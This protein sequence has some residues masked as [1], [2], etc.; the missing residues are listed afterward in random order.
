MKRLLE[1]GAWLFV[2][3]SHMSH[4]DLC[5]RCWRKTTKIVSGW[6]RSSG[7][8]PEVDIIGNSK[9]LCLACGMGYRWS[10]PK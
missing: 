6:F 2:Y 8:Y 4:P 3:R 7:R 5:P 1:W 10:N 9:H